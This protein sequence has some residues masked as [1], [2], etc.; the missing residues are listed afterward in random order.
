PGRGFDAAQ[1]VRAKEG[2]GV[3][4]D[5]VTHCRVPTATS[6]E[7]SAPSNRVVGAHLAAGIASLVDRGQHVYLAPRVGSEVVP[8]VVAAPN[9]RQIPHRAMGVILDLDDGLLDLWVALK[10]RANELPV[11][12]PVIFGVAG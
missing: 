2:L 3:T 10:P 12:W 9:R 5:G 6:V 7:S 1:K 4:A 8:F 11:P